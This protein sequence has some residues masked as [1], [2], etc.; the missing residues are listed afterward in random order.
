MYRYVIGVDVFFVCAQ[1]QEVL[2]RVEKGP[3]S[4]KQWGDKHLPI[5]RFMNCE[6][7]SQFVICPAQ[8]CI[9]PRIEF[10]GDICLEPTK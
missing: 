6:Q 9:L 7:E 10:W 2:K 3:K 8:E 1:G 5:L 4:Q